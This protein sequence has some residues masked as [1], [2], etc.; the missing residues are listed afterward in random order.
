MF[1]SLTTLGAKKEMV[2]LGDKGGA[3]QEKVFWEKAIEV[4]G[5]FKEK[6]HNG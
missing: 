5:Y 3:S 6:S 2:Q 4:D 1:L